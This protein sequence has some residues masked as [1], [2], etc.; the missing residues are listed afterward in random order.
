MTPA[1]Q[2]VTDILWEIKWWVDAVDWRSWV[3]H[4]VIGLPIGLVFGVGG[5]FAV[6]LIREL[7][8]LVFELLYDSDVKWLDH[9]MDIIAPVL[10]ALIVL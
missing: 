1:L 8:Q 7:E 10:L 6:Y 4:A 9:A 2:K 5:V 3:A